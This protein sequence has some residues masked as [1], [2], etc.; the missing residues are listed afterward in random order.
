MK[1]VRDKIPQ[2][3]IEDGKIP[4]VKKTN[5]KLEMQA[6]LY[7]KMIEELNEFH[8]EPSVEEAAD[9]Y[10]VLT[11]IC[12]HNQIDWETMVAQANHKRNIRGGFDTG[13][14]LIKVEGES[15]EK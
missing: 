14:I 10:E 1:L 11:A 12:Y 4:V 2:I 7:Q 9:M 6:F 15:H 5:S 13:T 3:I 8:S